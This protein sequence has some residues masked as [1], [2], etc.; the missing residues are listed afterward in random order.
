MAWPRQSHQAPKL[1]RREYLRST[2]LIVDSLHDLSFRDEAALQAAEAAE[3][4]PPLIVIV[5]SRLLL[6]ERS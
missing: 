3:G 2:L 6:E 1:P 4:E 5:M